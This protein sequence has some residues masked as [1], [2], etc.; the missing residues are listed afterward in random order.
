[1][2]RYREKACEVCQL[3]ADTL[4]RVQIDQSQVWRFVCPECCKAAAPNYYR[5]GGT[6]QSK[7]RH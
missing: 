7:K 4:F 1:M 6:W 5:Y 3:T 2:V